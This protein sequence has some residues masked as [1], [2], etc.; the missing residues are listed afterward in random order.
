MSSP[1]LE[2][3]VRE[4]AHTV[5]NDQECGAHVRENSDHKS[6]QRQ[7]RRDNDCELNNHA[8]HDILQ[9]LAV[10]PPPEVQ[11]VG[12]LAQ[13]VREEGD[14][15]G[16]ESNGGAGNA[17]SD[18]YIR[19]CERRAIIHTIA[20]HCDARRPFEWRTGPLPGDRQLHLELL[21]V[22]QFLLGFLV[23]KNAR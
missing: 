16:L 13:V 23:G 10:A 4:K 11:Y 14:V 6:T 2:W 5:E 18:P 20:A 8:E 12:E 22:H 17:H 15:G 7:E 1:L 21:N 19:R 9:D 3:V